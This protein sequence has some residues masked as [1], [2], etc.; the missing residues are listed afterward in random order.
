MKPVI[1]LGSQVS[2]YS[3][4]E[5]HVSSAA[6]WC[7]GSKIKKK[8]AYTALHQHSE[9]EF[10]KFLWEKAQIWEIPGVPSKYYSVTSEDLSG[11]YIVGSCVV[12]YCPISKTPGV[13]L[14]EVFQL[15]FLH[16]KLLTESAHLAQHVHMK[17]GIQSFN[18]RRKNQT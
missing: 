9:W 15:Q 2:F 18:E 8:T 11:S 13:L 10:P 14:A 4:P 17:S 16:A 1:F 3:T 6:E 5:F 7:P 12:I